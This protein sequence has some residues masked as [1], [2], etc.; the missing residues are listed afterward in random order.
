MLE[1]DN[2]SEEYLVK[3]YKNRKLY[4]TNRSCY[5]TL[6]ELMEWYNKGNKFLVIENETKRD[7]TKHTVLKA[8]FEYMDESFADKIFEMAAGRS[9]DTKIPFAARLFSGTI[10]A[11]DPSK[12]EKLDPEEKVNTSNTPLPMG[13]DAMAMKSTVIDVLLPFG[14]T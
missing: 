7:I 9:F 3:R 5:I 2:M 13:V 8:I 14:K 4:C 1:G 11:A 10:K 6:V 12:E